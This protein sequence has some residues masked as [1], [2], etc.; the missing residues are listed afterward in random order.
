MYLVA[1]MSHPTELVRRVPFQP[2]LRYPSPVALALHNILPLGLPP[3]PVQVTMGIV[4]EGI[5]VSSL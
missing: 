5:E 1:F 4:L 2:C 3:I